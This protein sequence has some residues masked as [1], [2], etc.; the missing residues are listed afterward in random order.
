MNARRAGL[1]LLVALLTGCAGQSSVRPAAPSVAVVE[2]QVRVP[3][4]SVMPPPCPVF[5]AP[6]RVRD[7]TVPWA[8]RRYLL[9]DGG[10]LCRPSSVRTRS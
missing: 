8:K 6:Y 9:P 7:L 10:G 1:L 2:H 5:K 4:I 3:P